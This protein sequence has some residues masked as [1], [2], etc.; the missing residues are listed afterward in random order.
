MFLLNSVNK[1]NK[2]QCVIVESYRDSNQ[3][4]CKLEESRFKRMHILVEAMEER[5]KNVYNAGKENKEC[6]VLK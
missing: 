2:Q 3:Q 4:Q 5:E 1:I 6:A